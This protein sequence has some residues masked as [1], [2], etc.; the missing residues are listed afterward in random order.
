MKS[1][2][3]SICILLLATAGI[4][5]AEES[6]NAVIDSA[7][8]QLTE[9]L[10]GRKNELTENR[11]AL[12]EIIDD[13][14]LPR[15]DSRFAAQLVL[16][17]HWRTASEEQQSRFI[18]AF[19]QANMDLLK[20]VPP[21]N[22]YQQ[23]WN[24]RTYQAQNPPARTVPGASG[25]EGVFVNSILAG[26]T[27]IAGG[28]V[29]HSILFPRVRVDDEALVQDSILFDGVHVG[30]GAELKNCIVEKQIAIPPQERIGLVPERDRE[31]FTISSKGIVVVPK[32]YRF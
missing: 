8:A 18:D 26:G 17:R 2:L 15:F 5:V 24:I 13:I 23:D 11:Q 12:Y 7:V 27:I 4:A 32:G 22:L 1:L 9:Q 21:L 19:Y 6:P 20:P 14:L 29:Q 16:A 25:T 28:S 31:R 3:A 10:D 30:A